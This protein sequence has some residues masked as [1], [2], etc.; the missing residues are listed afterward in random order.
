MLVGDIKIRLRYS[1]VPLR[2]EGYTLG[3]QRSA[4]AVAAYLMKYH[5]MDPT[6]ACKYI[7]SKR[8]EA[9]HFG[10]SLNFEKSLI[11]YYKQ[12]Q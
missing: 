12:L 7:L 4:A 9:F 3:R 1:L 5:N 6:Q 8:K 11:K 2:K 10:L